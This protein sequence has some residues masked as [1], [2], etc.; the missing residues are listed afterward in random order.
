MLSR[1]LRDAMTANQLV[2]L[3]DEDPEVRS[4]ADLGSR[5]HLS[6]RSVQRLAARYVGM[7]PVLLLRRRRLQDAAERIRARPELD[8]RDLAMELGFADQAHLT[9]EFRTVLG[10]TPRNYPGNRAD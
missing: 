3:L 4:V 9:R 8:L 1:S 7:S 5:L 10:F 2:D 6:Q